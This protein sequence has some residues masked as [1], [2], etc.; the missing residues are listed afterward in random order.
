MS[1]QSIRTSENNKPLIDALRKGKFLPPRDAQPEERVEA[2]LDWAAEHYPRQAIPAEWVY[3]A[4]NNMR[5]KGT[6]KEREIAKKDIRRIRNRA[7]REG[8][9][10]PY[11]YVGIK[12]MRGYR[13]VVDDEDRMDVKVIP[14]QR[15]IEKAIERQDIEVDAVD[16]VELTSKNRALLREISSG[17][18][19]VLRANLLGP[20][21]SKGS[22][23]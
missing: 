23:R 21:G 14:N 16:P 6:A 4:V 5:R 3:S 1:A 18:H 17:D 19:K 22:K 2:L 15:R 10:D 7:L 20:K 11:T 9:P 8:R 13:K 12:D